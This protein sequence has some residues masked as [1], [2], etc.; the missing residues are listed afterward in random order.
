MSLDLLQQSFSGGEWSPKLDARS[1]L[2]K[3]YTATR[4]SQN[5]IPTRYGPAERRPG[6]YFVAEVKDS[7]KKARLMPFKFS[8]VQAYMHE[9][10]DEY[11]RFFKDR[12]QIID[13]VGTEDISALDN[14]IAHWLLNDISGINV[15]DDDGGTH[16]M[17]LSVDAAIV[18]QTGKVGTGCFDLDGQYDCELAHHSDFSFTNDVNDTAFSIACW[19]YVTQQADL[20]VLLSKWQNLG[21]TEWRLSLTK[22]RR[23]Q[24]QLGDTTGSLGATTV[25]QWKLNDTDADQVVDDA[26][27]N[28]H[29]GATETANVVD[30]SAA[31]LTNLTPCFDLGGADAV[32]IPDNAAL[33]FDDSG[34]NPM[35]IAAWIYVTNTGVQQTIFSKWESTGDAE[36]RL[37]LDSDEKLNFDL[38]DA[39]AGAGIFNKTDTALS[40]GWH[41]VVVTYNSTGGANAET[42]VILYVD[43]VSKAFGTIKENVYVAME[44]G[45]TNALIG[46]QY[47][48][49]AVASYFADKIDNV[50]LFST[51]VLSPADIAALYNS[52]AGTETVGGAEISAISDDA[53][54]IGWHLF[55]TTYSA[56]ADEGTAAAG[57]IL[58]VDS[59][60]VDSTNTENANYT[61][62]QEDNTIE[63]RIGSQ[64]NSGDS[65]NEKFWGDKIDEVSVFGDVL[66]PAEVAGLYSTGPYE[67]SSPYLEADLFGIQR[68]QSADVMFGFHSGYNPRKLKR[69]EHALWEL[70]DI[71]FDWPPFME[72]NVTDTTIT[73]S[74]TVGTIE[75]AA[76]S[77]IF[78]SDH[79]GS[80]WL[81]RHPRTDNK[82][83]H[84][85]GAAVGF[86]GILVDVEG[87]WRLR[88]SGTWTGTIEVQRVYDEQLTLVL[89]AAPAGGAWSTD[90]IITGATSGDTCVIVSATDSTHYTIKQLSGSFT[91]DGEVLSNQSANSR[92]TAATWPRYEGWHTLTTLQSKDDQNFNVPGEE[93]LGNAYY[94]VECTEADDVV[95]RIVLSCERFY[96]Y[97]IVK[98]TGFTD[99]THATATVTRA[100]GSTIATKL[101]SEGAWSDERG[102]PTC[103]TFHEERLMV[104]GTIYQPHKIYGSMTFDWE[105]FRT[106]T[107]D[108]HSVKYEINAGE[109][110]AI[111]WL[112]SK[113]VLLLGTAGAEWKL[114]SFDADEPLTPGNPIK[115]RIQTSYGSKYIQAIMLANVVL[116]VVG[117]QTEDAPGRVVRG[118][119]YVFEKGESGGY[120]AFDY[121]TLAEHI[122]ESG[123]V[124]MAYQQQPEPILWAWLDNGKAIGMTFEP[125]QRVWGWFPL[126]TD[127]EIESMGVIPGVKED[128]V[129]CTVRRTK[130]DGTVIRCIEYMKPRDWGADQK[131]CFFVDSGLTFDGGDA[132][133]ITGITR[134]DPCVVTAVAHGFSDGDQVKIRY[135][136]GMSEVRDKVFSVSNPAANTFEL[137]DKLDTVDITSA[138]FTAF[139]A[140]ISGDTTYDSLDITNVSAADIVKIS[141]GAPVTGTGI[142]SNTTVTAINDNRFTMSAKATVTDT[143]VTITIVGNV[144][145][146]DNAFSGLDHLEG[147]TVSVLGDGTV[148]ENVVVISGAVTLTDY[149]NKVHIGRPY[150]S[151]LKPMKL[152]MPLQTG[153]ARAKIKRIHSIVFSFYKSLGCKFGP[154]TA[155]DKILFRKITDPMGEAVPLFTGEKVASFPGGYEL[156]ADIYVEQDQP[157]PLTVRSITPRL[158]LYGG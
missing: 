80:S 155:E 144:M 34:A 66:T 78:T 113:E 73:P 100:L 138:E 39:S 114:G 5:M 87:S 111:R 141:L 11:I 158:M 71:D 69:F 64:R 24:L 109:M 51:T 129:W 58:Y 97:G 13:G 142:P 37:Y 85:F 130:G 120:E 67:I 96:H 16:D 49:A 152:E 132:V 45:A 151:I 112:I 53:I 104:G 93:T 133:T 62:M 9:F 103:G 128:E 76:T 82:I 42:G 95:L 134:A 94:R 30:L 140:S 79:I 81:V 146:V 131:D 33:S 31:G 27:G 117:G 70:E 75:L 54:S 29:H 32:I 61:A 23:L 36:Y 74:G 154:L 20:Q 139:A 40:S 21:A 52:G 10:G 107:L 135:V 60:A 148:H 55:T 65:A 56:P 18:T 157:L 122:T 115:P 145:Q 7:S 1:D 150:K 68:I 91:D 48:N 108:D 43:E 90:D 126:I 102:Y 156:N 98:I 77:P 38:F 26:S 118:A 153:T 121:T 86:S 6:L 147:V 59:V 105:N 47:T 127:G 50:I 143:A 99:A 57:I 2:E 12:G 41:L 101:W 110:N 89:D 92:D 19:G 123:I 116:F 15:A 3:F 83:E 28:A 4:D 25:A 125:G 44:A 136:G 137:R 46:A 119:Q 17:T 88:T 124:G 106:G 72:E 22:D 63:I 8:T 149:F 84:D 14:V 35:S